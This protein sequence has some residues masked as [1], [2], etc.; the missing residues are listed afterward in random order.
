MKKIKKF[1]IKII[2]LFMLLIIPFSIVFRQE[3]NAATNGVNLNLEYIFEN[4]EFRLY[5]V[6]VKDSNNQYVKTDTFKDYPVEISDF[7]ESDKVSTAKTLNAYIQRDSIS[8]LS[9][10]KTNE[11]FQTSFTHLDEGLYLIEG[12]HVL[13]GDYRYSPSP[14]LINLEKE[15]QDRTIRMD[16]K[17]EKKGIKK[18]LDL[19]VYKVWEDNENKNRPESIELELLKNGEVVDLVELSE[20]NNWRHEWTDLPGRYAY[21]V[22]EKKIA[23]NY[24]VKTEREGNL[25][26]V[27]NKMGKKDDRPEI[28]DEKVPQTGQLWWPVPL[29]L[30]ISALFFIKGKKID[31]NYEE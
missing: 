11:R 25:I 16:L 23:K 22:T 7:E 13:S 6:A 20:K 8:P 29:L 17:Y 10:A 14:V 15:T 26:K 5:K 30:S 4:T 27:I 18:P 19:E 24:T 28:T 3:V 9:I 1:T 2:S 12:D 31:K 21:E